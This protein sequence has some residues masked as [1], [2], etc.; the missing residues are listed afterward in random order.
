M[1]HCH[2]P[3]GSAR[4]GP[5][6]PALVCLALMLG[7]GVG[8]AWAQPTAPAAPVWRCGNAYS[9]QPCGADGRVVEAEDARPPQ[10]QEQARA[11]Q[12]RLQ[13]LLDQ[14]EHERAQAE[15]RA[16]ALAEAQ[17]RAEH[18]RLLVEQRR[19]RA[20]EHRRQQAKPHKPTHHPRPAP[21]RAASDI[22]RSVKPPQ[23]RT[24]P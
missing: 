14:R 1:T 18:H 2:V 7:L 10:Q 16:R 4:R 8:T 22:R 13:G 20:A 12:Q 24:A 17:A 5:G 23:P 21:A 19:Q 9:H 3:R 6:L 11:Q 15:A